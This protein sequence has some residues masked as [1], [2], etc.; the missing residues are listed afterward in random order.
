MSVSV[1][2]SRPPEPQDSFGPDN[3]QQAAAFYADQGYVVLRGMVSADACDAARAAFARELKPSP[4]KFYRQSSS[5][6][7]ELNR[8]NAQGFLINPLI[9]FQDLRAAEFPDF[10]RA[11]LEVATTPVA[12]DFARTLYG[13]PA[14]I[15][16]TM[17][18]E[19]NPA[20]WAHQDSYYLDSEKIGGMTAAWIALEDIAEGAGRFFVCPGSHKQAL[21]RHDA[22]QDI[23]YHHDA[24]KQNVRAAM[25][26]QGLT[27]HAPALAK[28]DVLFWHALTIHGSQETTDHSRSRH[29]ITMHLI[30]QSHRF[31]QFQSRIKPLRLK[32]INGIDVH[33]PKDQELVSQRLIAWVEGTFP[34]A[35]YTAKRL[36]I[37]LL[38][39]KRH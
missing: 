12:H 39:G 8:F 16:Q 31:L 20:T 22:G 5:G 14:K 27:V 3:L 29:S 17:Y 2:Q 38:V 37:R 21:R 9:N 32:R 18:F 4:R 33:H 25:E 1:V 11:C 36:A 34:G 28:G 35:F 30:P 10:R 26:A 7:L 6:E 15:V 19:G 13:E 23:A 24:Y